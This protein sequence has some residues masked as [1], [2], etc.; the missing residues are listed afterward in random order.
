MRFTKWKYY[1]KALTSAAT[2]VLIDQ[3]VDVPAGKG[4]LIS[5]DP[6]SDFNRIAA[7]FQPR[8]PLNAFLEQ[9]FGRDVRIGRNVTIGEGT[10]LGPGVEIGHGAVIGAHVEIGANTLIHANVTIYDYTV[11][12]KECCIN[13]GAVIGSEAFY[14]KKRPYGRDKMLSVGRVVIG[15]HVDI[16]ANTTVDRGV[17]HDTVIGDYTKIDN[18][19]QIGHD[20]VIGKRCVIAAQVGIAGV[21]TVED[22]VC[23]WG[24]AGVAQVLTIGQ[25]ANLLARTGVMSSLEGGKSYGGMVADDARNFLK[26]EAAVKRLVELLP[27][28]ESQLKASEKDI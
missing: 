22:D 26:K 17:S 20:T 15:D 18:L 27:F 13:S 1:Q 10:K 28:L 8:L 23:I 7:H 11:I 25:G 14:F 24:Q 4:L 16:G 3:E 21:V 12:G 9:N 2:T 19:V 6:F 5:A